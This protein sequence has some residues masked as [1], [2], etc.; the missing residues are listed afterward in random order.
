[1]IPVQAG[2]MQAQPSCLF[3][4]SYEGL[5]LQWQSSINKRSLIYY[6]II[7]PA[8]M[9]WWH[10]WPQRRNK[11]IST[12]TYG[13]GATTLPVSKERKQAWRHL[14]NLPGLWLLSLGSQRPSGWQPWSRSW[15]AEGPPLRLILGFWDPGHFWPEMEQKNSPAQ[16]TYAFSPGD[17]ILC[18]GFLFQWKLLRNPLLWSPKGV[19]LISSETSDREFIKCP[20]ERE[21]ERCG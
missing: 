8:S 15:A 14:V 9:C 2:E 11:V 12:T 21:R 5:K 16:D 18:R 10:P 1:M 3:S 20:W 7:L 13:L 4:R 19:F 17:K 6:K